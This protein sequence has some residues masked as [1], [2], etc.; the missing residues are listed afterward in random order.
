MRWARLIGI[1]ATAVLGLGASLLIWS[2]P[3]APRWTVALSG[4]LAG[5]G[6]GAALILIGLL[7]VII[8]EDVRPSFRFRKPLVPLSLAHREA[9]M[10]GRSRYRLHPIRFWGGITLNTRFGLVFMVFDKPEY[11]DFKDEDA[12]NG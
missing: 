7:V 2:T 12:R 8:M 9:S 3:D 10:V 11:I 6:G 5:A 4:I 1:V